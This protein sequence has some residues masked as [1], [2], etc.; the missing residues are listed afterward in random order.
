MPNHE[1]ILQTANANERNQYYTNELMVEAAG[2]EPASE[3][4]SKRATTCVPGCLFLAPDPANRSAEPETSSEDLAAFP[5]A[6]PA[7]S[8]S[9]MTVNPP[10]T[11]KKWDTALPN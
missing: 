9:N 5:G 8:P 10:P 11:G 1:D 7:A 3:A 4:T 2:I 6:C